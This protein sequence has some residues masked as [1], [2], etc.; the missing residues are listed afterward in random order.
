VS[1]EKGEGETRG[2][3]REKMGK[4]NASTNHP[5]KKSQYPF[6]SG[7]WQV[8]WK[9]I[10]FPPGRKGEGCFRMRRRRKRRRRG[11][12]ETRGGEEKII[13]RETGR[14]RNIKRS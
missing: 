9:R 7:R 13:E 8:K 12:M 10:L 6:F 4:K 14:E 5:E 2:N 1:R 11:E 3:E